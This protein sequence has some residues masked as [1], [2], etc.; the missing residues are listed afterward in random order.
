MNIRPITPKDYPYIKRIGEQ[1]LNL[2]KTNVQDIDFTPNFMSE[3]EFN[4]F[5]HDK[6]KCCFL[7]ENNGIIIGFTLCEYH[8]ETNCMYVGD[9]CIDEIYR[10]D[11]YGTI[12]FNYMIDFAKELGAESFKCTIYG[13]N[14]PCLGFFEKYQGTLKQ[15]DLQYYIDKE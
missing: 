3:Q 8:V 10:H 12:L 5:I 1:C 2:H 6:S 13:F 4:E 14:K 7:I 11:G 9:M 15:V